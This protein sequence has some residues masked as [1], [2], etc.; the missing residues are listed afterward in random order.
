MADDVDLPAGTELRRAICVAHA[1]TP[2]ATDDR[3]G[4]LRLPRARMIGNARVSA[5][6]PAPGAEP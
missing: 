2:G 6:S 4:P 1:S 3:T 5:L